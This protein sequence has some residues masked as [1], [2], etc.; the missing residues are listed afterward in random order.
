MG[1]MM[2]NTLHKASIYLLIA[3]LTSLLFGI[4]TLVFSTMSLLS[5]IQ[6]FA[7]FMLI[8]GVS[9]SAGAWRTCREDS[10]WGFLFAYGILNILTGIAVIVYPDATMIILG[11]IVSINMLIG[12]ILQIVMAIHLHREIKQGIWLIV[13]GIITLVGGLY[14]YLI[15][16]IEA[17]TILYL[18]AIAALIL[19]LFLIS[20]SVKAGGWHIHLHKQTAQV[21]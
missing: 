5:L 6:L 2:T 14:I 4:F 8:K 19:A 15:P 1:V 11:F 21:R 17:I 9:L 16:R 18:I 7:V 3:G 12:G 20:L 13:S 10:H